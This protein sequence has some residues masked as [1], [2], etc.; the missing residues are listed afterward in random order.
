M[1]TYQVTVQL[2]CGSLDV[3]VEFQDKNYDPTDDEIHDAAVAQIEED[4]A[5]S[6]LSY[7]NVLS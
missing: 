6:K 4:L 5:M 2:Y 1:A 3:E 7:Y